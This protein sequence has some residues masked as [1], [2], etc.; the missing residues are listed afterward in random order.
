MKATISLEPC[1]FPSPGGFWYKQLTPFIIKESSGC[2]SKS[3]RA[4]EKLRRILIYIVQGKLH[5]YLYVRQTGTIMSAMNKYD[6]DNI[7]MGQMIYCCPVV[8]GS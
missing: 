8:N 4:I 7:P 3:Q 1:A 5:C 6:I 2:S